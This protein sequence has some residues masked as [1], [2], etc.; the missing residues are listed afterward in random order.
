MTLNT[1]TPSSRRTE[2][3]AVER[4]LA[5]HPELESSVRALLHRDAAYYALELGDVGGAMTHA[6]ACLELARA[7]GDTS[8]EVKAHVALALVQADS[9]DDLGAST[10][11]ALADAL[12]RSAGDDR[13]VALV[14]IN[15]SHYEL[16]RRHH[17]AALALLMALYHSPHMPSLSM[18]D[19]THLQGI[20]HVN[21]V[22]SATESLMA[23]EVPGPETERVEALL[24]V[25]A[26]F[27]Q[28]DLRDAVNVPVVDE[29][30]V[31]DALTRHALWA[32]DLGAARRLADQHV[33]LTR[34]A[35][36]PLLYGRA[37]L[38]RSRVHAETTE[39]EAAIE[40]AELAVRYFGEAASGLWE[41]RSREALA[42]VYA[43]AGR[44]REA[45]ET[46][47]AV[48]LGVENLYRD[49]HQ[50]RALVGQIEQQARDAEVRAGALAEAA[51]SDPLTGAPNRTRA[52]QVLNDLHAHARRGQPSAVALLDLDLFKRVN[53]IYGHLVGDAVLIEVTRLLSAELRA[54]DL[55]ARL[56][57]EEFLVILTNLT[58]KEAAIVCDRLRDVLHRASWETVAP[59]LVTS[60]SFGVAVLDGVQDI[61]GTLKA[62]DLALYAAKAAGRNS[63]RVASP[64]DAR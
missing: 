1:T 56:G 60:A 34:D 46:Q 59:G 18:P 64:H 42:T 35:D 62:A 49:Y 51:L 48:T 21:F 27:L 25:S 37:L 43:R 28:H 61:T 26:A 31:L 32:G 9:Y 30:G 14:A 16:E 45:Y 7:S 4:R 22:V 39:L 13:G 29:S 44:H 6:L 11:F 5:G 17:S 2:L 63:V 57:G 50:Q 55:L 19:S 33:H 54:H 15:A 40:D 23:G 38:D 20:F 24:R 47:R 3:Q 12:A 8:L 58:V 41:A 36:I 52:M 10:R 53:D